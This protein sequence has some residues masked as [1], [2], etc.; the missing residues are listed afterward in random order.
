MSQV[1][2]SARYYT[3]LFLRLYDVFVLWFSNRFAWRCPTP[4]VLLPFFKAHIGTEAHMD[5]GVGT[6]YYL[7][8]SVDV[9]SKT[10]HVTFSTSRPVLSK[11]RA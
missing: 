10:H 3:P 4:T 7:E 11:W 1:P 8:K 5:V 2:A 9:L 6:G